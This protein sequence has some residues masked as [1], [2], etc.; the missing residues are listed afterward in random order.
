LNPRRLNSLLNRACPR[1]E[2]K[3]RLAVIE[4]AR[5]GRDKLIFECIECGREDSIEVAFREERKAS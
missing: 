5:P 4:P 1:C 2:A 3:M